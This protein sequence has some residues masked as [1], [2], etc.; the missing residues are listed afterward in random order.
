MPY[1]LYGMG[2]SFKLQLEKERCTKN[3]SRIIR[4]DRKQR[5]RTLRRISNRWWDTVCTTRPIT[6]RTH[7]RR[8]VTVSLEAHAL[9][10]LPGTW[11]HPCYTWSN[12]QSS[13]I[14]IGILSPDTNKCRWTAIIKSL[15]FWKFNW[16]TI[17]W[18]EIIHLQMC[19][20]RLMA[21]HLWS[22]RHEEKFE[23]KEDFS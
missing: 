2:K 1:Q 9:W 5:L 7:R 11:S 3:P 23:A 10:G 21:T 8:S 12:G 15:P 20:Y 14:T 18:S 13:R 19:S 22:C 16:H 17:L 6:Y 4:T